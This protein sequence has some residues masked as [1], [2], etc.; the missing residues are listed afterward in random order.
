MRKLVEFFERLGY[1]FNWNPDEMKVEVMHPDEL[2]GISCGPLADSQYVAIQLLQQLQEFDSK[3]HYFNIHKFIRNR[4]L[5]AEQ[6]AM[7]KLVGGP[8]DG[9]AIR[10]STQGQTHCRQ[11]R[12]AWWAA[13][14]Q[15]HGQL[16][17]TFRGYATS[18]VKA[19]TKQYSNLGN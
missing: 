3:E 17:A 9:E 14:I 12:K 4:Y 13:Y 18:E 2:N 16:H 10:V 11:I 6:Q 15:E 7:A 1:E 8:F 19:K 5:Q